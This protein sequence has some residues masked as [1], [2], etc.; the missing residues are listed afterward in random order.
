MNHN[1]FVWVEKYRPKTIDECI[2]PERLKSKFKSF[3][4]DGET[5]CLILDGPSGVGKTSVA[6]ALMNE[7]D[8]EYLFINASQ[9]GNIDTLRTDVQQFASTS[10][11]NRKIKYVILDEADYSNPNSFQPALRGFIE[12]FHQNCRF[13]LTL[14][15]INKIIEPLKS[16]CDVIEFKFSKEELSFMVKEFGKH[17]FQILDDNNVNYEKR[18]V[19]DVIKIFYPD[20]RKII[21]KLQANVVD[22]RLSPN[23][24]V[25]VASLNLDELFVHLKEKNVA[26]FKKMLNW[27]NENK[28]TITDSQFFSLLY[29]KAETYIKPESIPQFVLNIGDYQHKHAFAADKE[30]NMAAF[31][32]SVMNDCEFL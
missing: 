5:P 11:L 28:Y 29:E 18:T 31:L 6:K 1:N 23:I 13:I 12:E 16:R 15:Q 7:I 32:T 22:G 4:K 14:N 20:W 25:D 10:S 30:I 3:V 26:S 21:N 24:F 9:Y 19:V 17:I 27:L 2:L 8:S